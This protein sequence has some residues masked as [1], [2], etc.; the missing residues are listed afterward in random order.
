MLFQ[1]IVQPEAKLDIQDGIDYY[2]SISKDLG[3][4][5]LDQIS[6]TLYE[7]SEF[8]YY[9]IRYDNVRM[10]KTKVFQYVIHFVIEE[11]SKIVRIYGVRSGL[12]NPDSSWFFHEDPENYVSGS[13]QIV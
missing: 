11:E 3:R 5:F 12:R 2:R 10:R 8:P 1:I 4:K 13:I 7:L 9:E 6:Q